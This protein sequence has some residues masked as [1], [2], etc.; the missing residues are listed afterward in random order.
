MQGIGHPDATQ[1]HYRDI[2]LA[3][4]GVDEGNF[5]PEGW[6]TRALAVLP[7]LAAG[8]RRRSPALIMG[9]GG[10]LSA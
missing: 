5:H 9:A 2:E 1:Q 6:V 3:F 10:I 7:S 8:T 4:T